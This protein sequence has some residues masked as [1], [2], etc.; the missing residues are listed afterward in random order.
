MFFILYLGCETNAR[1]HQSTRNVEALAAESTDINALLQEGQTGFEWNF[2]KTVLALE[3]ELEGTVADSARAEAFKRLRSKWYELGQPAISGYY[4][5]RWPNYW[6]RKPGLLP[7]RLYTICIQQ[8]QEQKIRDFAR[9]QGSTGL[10]KRHL[11]QPGRNSP[12]GEPGVAYIQPSAGQPMKGYSHAAGFKPKDPDNVLVLNTLR[13]ALQ[14]G[15]IQTV[16]RL[17][18][19]LNWRLAIQYDLPAGGSLSG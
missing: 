15:N 14:T 9:R 7:E 8:S 5:Q 17:E 11:A 2:F 4:A 3:T 12:S 6:A 19:A 10:R 16:E 1:R 18:H 13:L